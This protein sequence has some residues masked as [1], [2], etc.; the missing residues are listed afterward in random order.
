MLL[1]GSNWANLRL[2]E[3]NTFVIKPKESK[4][5]YVYASAKGNL[6][7]EHIFVVT[8]KSNDKVLQQIPLKGN[9][10]A[11]AKKSLLAVAL[12]NILQIMLILLVVFLVAIGL[13]FGIRKYSQ[14]EEELS[15]KEYYSRQFS[16]EIPEKGNGEVYY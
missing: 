13:L 12:K 6:I 7:G 3:S 16:E 14:K 9:V 1:D 11:A 15:D 8:V 10:I 5:S 2:A 4:T